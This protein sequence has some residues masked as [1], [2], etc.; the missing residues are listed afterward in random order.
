MTRRWQK[1]LGLLSGTGILFA[2]LSGCFERA[3][4]I[5]VPV[6]DEC[7]FTTEEDGSISFDLGCF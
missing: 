4:A 5:L 2:S 1:L 7:S 3:Q 6:N